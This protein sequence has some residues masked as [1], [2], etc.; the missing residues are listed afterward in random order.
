MLCGAHYDLEVYFYEGYPYA[1]VLRFQ[2]ISVISYAILKISKTLGM[3]FAKRPCFS[4]LLH[5]RTMKYAKSTSQ[6]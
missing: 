2:S 6:S 1:I 3:C 4:L 5:I